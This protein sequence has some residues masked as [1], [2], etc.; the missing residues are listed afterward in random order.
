MKQLTTNPNQSEIPSRKG[1]SSIF[2][3]LTII[4]WMSLGAGISSDL[5]AE[6]QVRFQ[7]E[8][9]GYGGFSDRYYTNGGRFDFFTDASERN[10]N[11]AVFSGWNQL[12]SEE[13]E[14]TKF[15]SGF[16]IA[17][18]F[19]TPTN[20]K[21]ADISFGDRPYASRAYFE[22]SFTT[23]TNDT[24]V[25]TG[26]ELGVIGQSVGAKSSQ[27]KFHNYIGSPI[28]EGWDTQIPDTGTIGI[29][30]DI[31]KF[32]NPYFGMNYNFR[33][34]NAI[35]D[36]SIG[37][38]FRLGKVGTTPGP[39]GN[40]LNP[41][42]PI[43]SNQGNGYWYF[44]INPAVGF[45][46]FNATIEGPL[47]RGSKYRINQ[48][49]SF[50]SNLDGIL[51]NPAPEVSFREAILEALIQDNGKNTN[52]RFLLFNY[53]LVENTNNPYD[54]GLNYLLFNNIF[55]GAESLE[56][57][58]RL[59]LFK[60]L[61]ENWESLGERERVIALYS[62]FRPDGGKIPTL[63]RYYSYEILSQYILDPNQRAL[64]LE[65]LRQNFALTEGKT[66][67][68]GIQR[69]VG[70]FR[71]GFVFVSD[72]GFLFTLNYS[73]QTIDFQSAKGLPQYHQWAGFQLGTKF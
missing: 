20:I 36:A 23:W 49:E 12:F 21:K 4:I 10:W 11:R 37:F 29:R 47:G 72:G 53:F 70:F 6:S 2:Q 67:V 60:S 30:T 5:G 54:I 57:G 68:A 22:T 26:L 55:N 14:D 40:V 27:K 19:Y 38:I 61:S 43:L 58:L 17:Q 7:T 25:T 46:G 59:F 18:E 48:R 31:R 13:T 69:A 44:Y 16:S 3:V 66:Y 50:F 35:S 42:A 41:G 32:H 1:I 52:E 51:D 56:P 9:D 71:A 73:Y 45:Q 33:L 64:F 28:P 8:N 15:Y 39:E 65:V 34:G 24:S 63:I 62:L